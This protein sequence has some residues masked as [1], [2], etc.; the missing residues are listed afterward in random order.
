MLVLGSTDVCACARVRA[1][2]SPFSKWGFWHLPVPVE[3]QQLSP[4][5]HLGDV[6]WVTVTSWSLESSP[7]STGFAPCFCA[8]DSN[9]ASYGFHR[10]KLILH[11][12]TL[13]YLL[14]SEIKKETQFAVYQWRAIRVLPPNTPLLIVNISD[15]TKCGGCAAQQLLVLPG[16][17]ATREQHRVFRTHNNRW[18]YHAKYIA[19]LTPAPMWSLKL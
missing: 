2:A 9:G 7:Q 6:S 19:F 4:T 18:L 17:P 16:G 3:R 5:A 10:A 12:D 14:T 13:F 11:E 15:W 1:S 8:P